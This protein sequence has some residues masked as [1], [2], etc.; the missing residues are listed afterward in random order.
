MLKIGWYHD[1][2]VDKSLWPLCYY[3]QD[4]LIQL[5]Q[6]SPPP[7]TTD[8]CVCPYEIQAAVDAATAIGRNGFYRE[9]IMGAKYEHVLIDCF[10]QSQVDAYEA[11]IPPPYRKHVTIKAPFAD[12]FCK[13]KNE[14]LGN[15]NHSQASHG[16]IKTSA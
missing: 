11:A 6:R 1:G 14:R 8:C 2:P 9:P 7:P 15:E 3:C 10:G 16:H 5:E 13:L 4:I 12:M